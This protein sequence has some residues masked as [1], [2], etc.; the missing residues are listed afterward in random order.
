MCVTWHTVSVSGDS[1]PHFDKPWPVFTADEIKQ[2]GRI[3]IPELTA[4]PSRILLVAQCRDANRSRAENREGVGDDMVHAKVITKSSIDGGRTWADFT[5]LTAISHS[6]GAAI[7]DAFTNRTVLQFQFHPNANPELN[8]TYLQRISDDD[9]VSWGADRDITDQLNGCNPFRPVEM[10]VQSA[11]SKIQT[12]SGRLVFTGHSKNNDSCVWFS[13]DHGDSYHASN[14]FV[15]NEISVA[16]VSPGKLLLNGRGLSFGW[17]PNRTQYVSEDDGATWGAPRPSVLRDN[18]DFGCEAALIAV[19]HRDRALATLYFSEP[20][21]PQRTDLVLRCSH[22]SGITWPGVLAMN[23]T[24]KGA[25]YSAMVALPDGSLLVM[26]EQGSSMEATVVH[27]LS[28]CS[29]HLSK[30]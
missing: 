15:G 8:S 28:W 25:A 16:E 11:G 3:R 27:D 21:G 18:N 1:S 23:G 9:G 5:V 19:P 2:C 12:S 17:K 29:V 7:F 20:T 10:Q 26:W 4:C 14:R 24:H 13:D 6:H 22:D 30:S